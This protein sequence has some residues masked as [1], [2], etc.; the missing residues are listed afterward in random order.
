MGKITQTGQDDKIGKITIS[1]LTGPEL[2]FR[3]DFP[4]N[5]NETRK[6]PHE[7]KPHPSINSL[8]YFEPL[9]NPPGSVWR[10]FPELKK[11]ITLSTP[12]SMIMIH[13]QI[14]YRARDWLTCR[15]MVS[16]KEETSAR[17]IDMGKDF[18]TCSGTWIG[19]LSAGSHEI[20]VMGRCPSSMWLGDASF[21]DLQTKALTI[22]VLG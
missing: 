14:S 8:N 12:S 13:Y 18:G 9:G 17:S 11:T 7:W 20:K 22:A 15:L 16:G 3:Y 6:S 4:V 2:L 1:D 21:N 19:T 5:I 10:D